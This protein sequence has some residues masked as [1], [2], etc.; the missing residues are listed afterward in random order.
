LRNDGDRLTKPLLRQGDEFIEIEWDEA[1]DRAAAGLNRIRERDGLSGLGIYLGNPGSHN[2]GVMLGIPALLGALPVLMVSAASIDSFPRFLADIFLY[3]NQ[4]RC[5]VPDIDRTDFF[6]I[7]GGNP[8]VSNG[9]MMGA[10]NMPAR[11]RA[12]KQRGGK[13][14]V[15]DP[16]R[17]ETA[18]IADDY[19]AL[20]PGTDA[21]FAMAMLDTLFKENRVQLKHLAAFTRG[22]D[23]LRGIV[24]AFPAE[25][26]APLVGIDAERIRQLARDFAAAKTAVAYG[27]VG[28]CCQSFGTLATWMID[29]LNVV[30]GNLDATGGAM[31]PA[32]VLP[33]IHTHL[34]YQGEVAPYGQMLSR[35]SQ[36][37][38]L[39]PSFPANV[40]WEE[41]ETPGVGQIRGLITIAGNPA[42]SNP[43]AGRVT[44]AL[45]Q[46]EFM[47]SVDIY[48]NETSRRADIILPPMDHLKRSEHTFIYGEWMVENAI[49]YSPPIFPRQEGDRSDWDI[50]LGLAARLSNVDVETYTKNY[51]QG[52][53]GAILPMLPRAP[54]SMSVEDMLTIS[55]EHPAQ[56]Q[57]YDVLLRTGAYGDGYGAVPGGITMARLKAQPAGISFGPMQPKQMPH[58]LD[59]PD[60]CI[61]LAPPLFSQDIE[62]LEAEISSGR[63]ATEQFMLI[64]RRDIRSNNSWFRNLPALAKGRERCVALMNPDDASELGL[65]NGDRVRLRSRVGEI[66]LPIEISA[67]MRTRVISVPHGFG[68]ADELVRMSVA[69]TKISANVNLL[70]DDADNDRLS[71]NSAFNG[72]A[73]TVHAVR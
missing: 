25:R 70:S 45:D 31:F 57:L 29:C 41:I 59:T 53:I 46:L 38:A 10:P 68:H 36:T 13:L 35:V 27:R 15:I 28:A 72:V 60:K 30:T 16:R 61:A 8:L 48:L 34:A 49:A 62:R 20:R 14:I 21:L 69:K 42:L 64:N 66:E 65:H 7:F 9:S 22:L 58:I 40:L 56:E 55:A 3:G 18:V 52:F 24:S 23:A 26:V 12:L 51:A 33:S 2:A 50:L 39:G 63:F 11:L 43:N 1:L 54:N 67:D 17:S 44:A 47:V 37:P 32:P 71:G 4:A 6:L 5:P 19:F 73:I